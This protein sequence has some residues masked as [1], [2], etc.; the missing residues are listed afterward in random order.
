MK[1]CIVHNCEVSIDTGEL[2]PT[3]QYMLFNP[4]PWLH[5]TEKEHKTQDV[6]NE[7]QYTIA[8]E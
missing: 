5:R 8:S 6:T 1:K 7:D 2:C 3:H 4:S